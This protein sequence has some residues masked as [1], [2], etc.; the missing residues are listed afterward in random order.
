VTD[1]KPSPGSVHTAKSVK[2]EIG[3]RF[4]FHEAGGGVKEY[5]VHHVEDIFTLGLA[6]R[7][8]LRNLATGG[9][10]WATVK[11]LIDDP[12]PS[13]TYFERVAT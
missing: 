11:W 6:A 12:A 1:F 9:I 13:G 7:V 5:V 4:D 3:D 10:G 8:Q 2:V